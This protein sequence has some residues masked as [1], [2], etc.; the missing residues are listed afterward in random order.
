MLKLMK[1][2]YVFELKFKKKSLGRQC[3]EVYR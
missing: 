2:Y 3:T 1:T